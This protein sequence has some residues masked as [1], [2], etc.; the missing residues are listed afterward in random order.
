MPFP[1]ALSTFFRR[2]RRPVAVLTGVYALWVLAGF[3]LIPAL[4]KPRI[5][6]AAAAAL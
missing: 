1:A 2:G 4:A 6:R 5:E 3:F